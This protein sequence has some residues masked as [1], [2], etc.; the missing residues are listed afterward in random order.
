MALSF[1]TLFQG[2][3]GSSLLVD[4]LRSHPHVLVQ[5]EALVVLKSAGAAAQITWTREFFSKPRPASCKAVGFKTKLTDVVDSDAFSGCLRSANCAILHLDR[6]DLV[7]QAISWMRA[8]LLFASAARHNICD[9]DQKQPPVP[10]DPEDFVRRVELLRAG[11][12][13]LQTY[14]QSLNLP[15]LHVRYE[16]IAQR[17]AAVFAQIQAFLGLEPRSL[18]SSLMKHTSDDLRVDVPNLEELRGG[19]RP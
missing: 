19:T 14:V 9:G 3:S 11:R 10:L 7:K 6:E 15:T 1:V 16:A 4:K 5:G 17:P 8:D 12:Q 13:I 2:R 18:T